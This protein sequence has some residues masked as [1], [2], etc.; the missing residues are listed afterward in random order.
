MEYSHTPLTH[1]WILYMEEQDWYILKIFRNP[2]DCFKEKYRME[3]KY[4]LNPTLYIY[5]KEVKIE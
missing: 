4:A 1:V 3:Q 5:Y 2:V